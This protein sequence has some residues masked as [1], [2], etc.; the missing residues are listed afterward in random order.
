MKLTTKVIEAGLVAV[1]L[2]GASGAGAQ[3]LAVSPGVGTAGTVATLTGI[4]FGSVGGSV[5]IGPAAAKIVSWKLDSVTFEVPVVAPGSHAL[6]LTY[7]G[8]I[9]WSPALSTTFTVV[10]PQM[11]S[12][13]HR[14]R[15]L[16]A[17]E[18]VTVDGAYFGSK[19][20]WVWLESLSGAVRLCAIK[21]W[22]DGSITF[23]V[24]SGLTGLCHLFIQNQVGIH[25]DS[26]WGTFIKKPVNPPVVGGTYQGPQTHTTASCVYFN[27]LLYAFYS[28]E[29]GSGDYIHY[30]LRH[31]D[32]SWESDAHDVKIDGT[33]MQGKAIV[34]P[35]VADGTLYLFF[36][37]LGGKLDYAYLDNATGTWKGYWRVG[38]DDI[39]DPDAHFAA[40]YNMVRERVDVYYV[41]D[42]TND[43]T[44]I[45]LDLVANRWST[46]QKVTTQSSMQPSVSAVFYQTGASTYV[47]YVAVAL[48]HQAVVYRVVDAA[49]QQTDKD[50]RWTVNS[51]GNAP[52]LVDL[53][54]DRMALLWGNKA[55]SGDHDIWYHV[56]DKATQAW[57]GSPVKEISGSANSWSPTGVVHY[58]KATDSTSCAG[59]KWWAYGY[60]V[61]GEHIGFD[62][63]WIFTGATTEGWWTCVGNPSE[64]VFGNYEK[65]SFSTWPVIGVI[66]LPPFIINSSTT[67][68]NFPCASEFDCTRVEFTASTTTKDVVEGNLEAGG[69]FCKEAK[70]KSPLTFDFN[71]GA[72]GSMGNE[73]T[74]KVENVNTLIRNTEGLIMALYMAPKLTTYQFEWYNMD[75][76]ATG[77]YTYPV[78]MTGTTTLARTFNPERGP[79]WVDES[80]PCTG[81]TLPYMESAYLH[82]HEGATDTERLGTYGIPPSTYTNISSVGSWNQSASSDVTWE[83]EKTNTRSAGGYFKFKIGA[84][85]AKA[86]GIGGGVEGSI[87]VKYTSQTSTGVKVT[88]FIRNP[89]PVH[90]TDIGHFDVTGYWMDMSQTGYW[91]PKHRAALGDAPFFITYSV[92]NI[93]PKY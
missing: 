92:A 2:L 42:G 31:E 43:L 54:E 3:T 82:V 39:V 48:D 52:W 68:P 75:K 4:H 19:P 37:G 14:P 16:V 70:K 32:G 80:T 12:P 71:I 17:G 33:T 61:W 73:T 62:D 8:A 76:E 79:C 46:K 65:D 10:G 34:Q 26:F 83:G 66:D 64:T 29:D 53:G 88:T 50:S 25:Q 27:G 60:V 58:I 11:S 81:V 49:I 72:T 93:S 1:L 77:I 30:R 55:S 13:Q 6:R 7:G 40:V 47:T 85:F 84:S 28:T 23:D 21:W 41:P 59:A 89:E 44:F 86:R 35:V 90:S 45:S 78:R 63:N 20:G 18:T 57:T 9:P 51:S 56:F 69:Y 74:F 5:W 38:T 24:P 36:T 91:I 22:E 87:D 15:Y 67:D